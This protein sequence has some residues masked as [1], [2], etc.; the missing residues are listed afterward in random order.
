MSDSDN[1]QSN[2]D[3]LLNGFSM[4]TSWA[5]SSPD[6]HLMNVSRYAEKEKDADFRTDKKVRND[7]R[8]RGDKAAFQ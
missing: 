1:Q 6:Q 8:L 7:K 2:L 3:A 4:S 5:K